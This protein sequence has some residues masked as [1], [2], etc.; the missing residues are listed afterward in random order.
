MR[1]ALRAGEKLWNTQVAT[2]RCR[3][4]T[5]LGLF[6]GALLLFFS[7]L[8]TYDEPAD[9]APQAAGA[10]PGT[11]ELA[12]L[13]PLFRDVQ[14]MLAVALGLLLAFLPRY[15]LGAL[16]FTFLLLNVSAQWALLLRGLLYHRAGGRV[17]LGLRSLLEAEF[18]ATAV[19]ISAGAVLGSTS[20]LQL[21][22]AALC[23]VPV[24]LASEWA[25]LRGLGALDVGGT[26]T[27]H[28]FACYFGL[29]MSW[30]LLRG[31]GARDAA[32][33]TRHSD[34][35]SLVGMLALWVLWPSFV[36]AA[37]EPGAAQR[38]AALHTVLAAR[39]IAGG[40]ME[41]THG[42]RARG[43]AGAAAGAAAAPFAAGA[44]SGRGA[45]RHAQPVAATSCPAALSLQLQRA[46]G[47]TSGAAAGPGT[48][49][50]GCSAPPSPPRWGQHAGDTQR[51][52]PPPREQP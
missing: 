39:P 26:V 45:G 7:L 50:A 11:K 49:A 35:L 41:A 3:L 2:L 25:I 5:F 34:T 42:P 1:S 47:G 43:A 28:V 21:L 18:A 4:P 30:A 23:E 44:Q 27:I 13:F 24:Y 6:Q 48:A 40:P 9:G 19:L 37:C 12:G 22:L 17:R 16:A 8:V 20:P 36:A 51:P 10:E 14:A 29:A 15:G 38:R 33:P 32:A 52:R 46:S 31:S